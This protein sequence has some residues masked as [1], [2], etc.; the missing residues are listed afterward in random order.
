MVIIYG[1]WMKANKYSTFPDSYTGI[2]RNKNKKE[3][4]IVKE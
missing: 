1:E 2:W 4:N 3:E